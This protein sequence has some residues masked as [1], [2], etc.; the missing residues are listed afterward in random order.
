[1][2]SGDVRDFFTLHHEAYRE[3]QS[4]GH[5]QDL[6]RLAQELA[7]PTPG[8]ILDVATGTGH[9]ALRFAA[10]GHTVTGID[11]TEA[12]LADA[13]DLARE[14]GFEGR[15]SFL[16]GDA[17]DLPFASGTFDAVT[18]R[19]AAHHFADIPAFLS[20][21]G[22]VLRAGG[23]LGVAD[24]TADEDSIDALNE[25]ERLRDRSHTA[26]LSPEAWREAVEQAGFRI[27]Y[28]TILSEDIPIGA[29]LQPVSPESD[30]GRHALG[31]IA[32]GTLPASIVTLPDT[33]H[34]HRVILVAERP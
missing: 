26:A 32:H 33:F 28:L 18:C 29:W 22:R 11:L 24:L 8:Q 31:R 9:T 2:P 17:A 14:R 20:E 4:H 30:E 27:L 13:R 34:K 12:M 15:T 25:L 1:M 3:S 16:M 5:G 19:R 23:R 6:D 7:L 21:A 10:L